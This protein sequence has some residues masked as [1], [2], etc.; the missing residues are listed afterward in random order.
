MKFFN[1][2]IRPITSYTDIH[3]KLLEVFGSNI[4]YLSISNYISK[5]KNL[6]TI[7]LSISM[8]HLSNVNKFNYIIKNALLISMVYVNTFQKLLVYGV[9]LHW[10]AVIGWISNEELHLCVDKALMSDCTTCLT[11]L[12]LLF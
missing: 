5:K 8:V 6:L 11:C 7:V 9:F 2:D 1:G 12:L 3:K 4:F 10:K